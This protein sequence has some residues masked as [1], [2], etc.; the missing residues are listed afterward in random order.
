MGKNRGKQF[1][2]E[3]K[4]AFAVAQRSHYLLRLYDPAGGYA[5]IHNFADFVLFISPF[6]CFLE[7]KST[8]G[9][10]FN[11]N[12]VSDNQYNGLLAAAGADKVLAGVVV[13]FKDKDFT[14]F[15]PIQEIKRWRKNG[16]KSISYVS[17]DCLHHIPLNGE[18]RKV[19]FNY[20]AESFISALTIFGEE[21]WGNSEKRN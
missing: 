6:I 4:K 20:D 10:T 21:L 17:I 16:N 15:I 1:E 11:F 13:W 19:L 5:G 9:G 18:K 12:Q 2:A 8:D 14:C 7:L 3:F